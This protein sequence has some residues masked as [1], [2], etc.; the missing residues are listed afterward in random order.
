MSTTYSIQDTTLASL[1]NAVRE[2]WGTEDTFTPA[3]M[4]SS[5]EELG[6]GVNV[7]INNMHSYHINP[8]TNRC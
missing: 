4:A 8:L 3:Q 6:F 5:I 7:N 2:V 1:G